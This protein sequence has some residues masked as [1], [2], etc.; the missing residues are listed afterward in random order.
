MKIVGKK[1]VSLPCSKLEGE[2]RVPGD[3]SISH[4]A[5]MLGALGRGETIIEGFL[6]SKDCL[7]TASCMEK[8][9]AKVRWKGKNCVSIISEGRNSLQEP[10]EV[11]DAGNSGTTARLI[12][13]MLASLP[14]FAVVDGDSSLK[15]RPMDRIANPLR[16]MGACILGRSNAKFLPLSIKGA[17]LSPISY[18]LP[19]ASA[20]VKSAIL[21]AALG[22]QGVTHLVEP[23]PSRDHTERM[24]KYLGVP[25]KKTGNSIW[26]KGGAS[27]EGQYF[28]V[29]GDISSA[30]FLL[31]AAVIVPGSRLVIKE[32]GV[33]QTR[34]GIIEVLRAMGGDI[35]LERLQEFSG[36]P[37]A[38]IIVRGKKKPLTAITVGGSLIPR[39]I[40]ELPVLAVAASLAQGETVIKDAKELR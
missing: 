27:W 39:L 7:S 22:A 8:L 4:R 17:V 2:F 18:R 11:L 40:D 20:Q 21:L 14:L 9:G 15:K 3:K 1:L 26:I 12:T 29:P 35:R 23:F 32:V 37:V 36:E 33:N 16:Q 25:L 10:L 13:G 30:A 31:V 19:V 5:L 6:A 28:K 34:S 24:L 38:D